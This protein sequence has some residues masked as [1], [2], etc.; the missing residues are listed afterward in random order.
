MSTHLIQLP[1]WVLITGGLCIFYT[2]IAFEMLRAYLFDKPKIYEGIPKTPR[3]DS[4]E[5]KLW[6]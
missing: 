5:N 4:K 6:K 2:G 3:M 1:L